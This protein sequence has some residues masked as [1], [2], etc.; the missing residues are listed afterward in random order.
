MKLKSL[1]FAAAAGMALSAGA[2]VQGT[3][4]TPDVTITDENVGQ[5]I[6]MHFTLT[7][8]GTITGEEAGYWKTQKNEATGEMEF[9]LD[10]DGNKIKHYDNVS[11]GDAKQW[12]NIQFNMTFPIGLHPALVMEDDNG[13][14]VFATE[15]ADP[16]DTFYDEAGADVKQI[17]RP[18]APC[19][20]FS[21]NFNNAEFY[22]N[23]KTVGA[24]MSATWNPEGEVYTLY[25]YADEEM[26]NGEYDFM[27]YCKWIDQADGDNTI[28]TDDARIAVCKVIVDRTVAPT[29][30][31]IAGVVVDEENA[32]LEGVTVTAI[33]AE[34]ENLTATT[35]AEGAYSI[36]APAD[37]VY[38][39]TFAKEGYVT[40]EGVTEENAANVVMVKEAPATRLIEGVVLD[41]ENNPIEGV[42]VTANAVVDEPAGMFREPAAYTATTNEAGAYSIEVPN[43][44]ATYTLT[45]TKEGYV[46]QTLAEGEAA[47]VVLAADAQTGGYDINGKTVASVKY[48]NAA[49]VA[50]DNAFQGVNIVVTKYA[51]GSQSVVKVVK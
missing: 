28:G 8:L 32:P 14:I 37:V 13:N 5:L 6:A 33:P 7:D 41:E 23:H 45:F 40:Q 3:L 44:G 31:T 29:T 43:D 16:E 34:G 26:A 10:D 46:S 51:D 35:D 42:T 50:S 9:V 27:I 21:G 20:T 12:K 36:E 15:D 2:V 17:G 19:V 49:G 24:N 48:Y 30:K 39:L 18:K 25:V 4:S 11:V 22:P 38:T 1:L 47:N